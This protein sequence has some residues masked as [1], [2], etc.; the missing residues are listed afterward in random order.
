MHWV[1][2]GGCYDKGSPILYKAGE[3]QHFYPFDK[4][5]VEL[6]PIRKETGKRPVQEVETTHSEGN[7]WFLTFLIWLCFILF[8]IFLIAAI[9]LS[10]LEFIAMKK[11]SDNGKDEEKGLMNDDQKNNPSDK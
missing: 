10:V 6:H 2:T 11:K 3:A 1:I 4:I 8:L 5:P 7:H 9:V